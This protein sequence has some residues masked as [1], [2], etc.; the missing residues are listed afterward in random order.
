MYPCTVEF[1][2]TSSLAP[3]M[4]VFQYPSKRNIHELPESEENGSD[5]INPIDYFPCQ[6]KKKVFN[7]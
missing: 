3:G 2:Y 7:K 4:F 5:N 1:S 6:E